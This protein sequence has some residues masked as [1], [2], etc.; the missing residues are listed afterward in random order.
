MPSSVGLVRHTRDPGKAALDNRLGLAAAGLDLER[1]PVPR[2]TAAFPER[3]PCAATSERTL[4]L[5]T[6]LPHLLHQPYLF[7]ISRIC[8]D[9]RYDRSIQSTTRCLIFQPYDARLPVAAYLTNQPSTRQL[10]KHLAG[11]TGG[12][13][14]PRFRHPHTLKLVGSSPPFSHLGRQHCVPSSRTDTFPRLCLSASL[15]F[16]SQPTLKS[17]RPWTPYTQRHRLRMPHILRP[18]IPDRRIRVHRSHPLF[19]LPR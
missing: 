7:F 4:L 6:S 11:L 16:L 12:G 5:I 17:C 3:R 8:R 10:P 1:G 14:F 19:R 18:Q 15:F 9:T 2:P 13:I